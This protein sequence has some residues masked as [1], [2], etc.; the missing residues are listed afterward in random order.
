MR[1]EG[2]RVPARARLGRQLGP[3][4]RGRV[5]VGEEDRAERDG[6]RADRD[7][8]QRVEPRPDTT[9]SHDRNLDGRGAGVDARE[10]DRASG[11]G[12]E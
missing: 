12:P 7:E 1:I 6:G 10:R 2:I 4:P 8:L 5:R 11:P 9:H 3:D